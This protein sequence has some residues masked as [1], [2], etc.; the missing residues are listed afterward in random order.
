MKT[1]LSLILC[2]FCIQSVVAQKETNSWIIGPSAGVTF[3]NG[4]PQL[5]GVIN[6][7]TYNASHS[8]ANGHLQFVF[9]SGQVLD[10]NYSFQQMGPKGIR[11]P[12]P[13]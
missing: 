5:T 8:D 4:N 1:L 9:A 11:K 10:R 7:G 6:A 12:R 3:V 2:A 13:V